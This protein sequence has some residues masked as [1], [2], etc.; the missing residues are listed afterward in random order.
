MA[1]SPYRPFTPS[2]E[3]VALM[4]AISGNTVNGMGETEFRQAS[5]VYGHGPETV[6]HGELQKWFYTQDPD[7]EA[8]AQA[9]AARAKSL[10]IK[11]P[12]VT[13]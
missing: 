9:L 10:D 5:P 6:E 1:K 3:Q 8:I 2:P 12:P 7:N 11:V 13:D 4:P